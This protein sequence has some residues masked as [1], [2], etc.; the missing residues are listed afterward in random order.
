[1]GP[2]S[3]EGDDREVLVNLAIYDYHAAIDRGEAPDSA[4]WAARNPEIAPQLHAYFD[5]LAGLGLLR[6]PSPP[7]PPEDRLGMTIPLGETVIDEPGPRP[8]ED[9]L[10][11]GD[12]LGDYVLLEKLG[13]G[14]QGVVWKAS[15][16]HSR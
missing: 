7:P 16:Q 11:P 5:D 1:M 14:G 6:P 2:E 8:R 12:V 4:E 9:D 3:H 10:R 13:E 15:P